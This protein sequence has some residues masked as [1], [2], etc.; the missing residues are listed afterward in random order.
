MEIQENT[1]QNLILEK[2]FQLALDVVE[3]TEQLEKLG[4]RQ[5]ANQLIR[6]GTSVGANAHEAQGAESPKDF[7]HKMKISIKE[8]HET[9]FW[10][11]ICQ[12]SPNYPDCPELMALCEE[13][14]RILMAITSSTKKKH[15][16]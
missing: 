13:N 12:R 16:L 11:K 9:K 5:I 14:L 6:S 1:R 3:Y 2:S 15:N 7:L 8:A 10:L 4:K